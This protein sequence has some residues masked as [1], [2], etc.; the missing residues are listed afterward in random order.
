ML[1][2]R[3]LPV[4]QMRFPNKKQ[5]KAM[6]EML[7][8]IKLHGCVFICIRHGK[9]YSWRIARRLAKRGLAF[10]A[11]SKIDYLGKYPFRELCGFHSRE[12]AV[13]RYRT[14]LPS[15]SATRPI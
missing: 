13:S 12:I 14:L 2:V 9:G 7:K 1:Q 10:F 15:C 11:G 5:R 6:R 4:E 3:S 8:H